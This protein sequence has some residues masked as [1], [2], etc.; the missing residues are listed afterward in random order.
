MRC[1]P[2]TTILLLLAASTLAQTHVTAD[3]TTSRTWTPAGSPFLVEAWV[4]IMPDVSLAI[5][6]GVV[7]KFAPG[8][9]GLAMAER[10]TL[11]AAGTAAAPI[12]F[13][14]AAAVP[15]PGDYVGLG[16][17][18]LGATTI[19][20]HCTI[21]FAQIG[22]VIG[23]PIETTE[24]EVRYCWN[25]IESIGGYGTARASGLRVH[26]N[27][28]G[29]FVEEFSG[30]ELSR[31]RIHDNDY[32]MNGMSGNIAVSLDACEFTANRLG[33]AMLEFGTASGCTFADNGGGGLLL[34]RR[35]VV[36]G[37]TFVSNTGP[38]IIVGPMAPGGS[39]QVNGCNFR[40]NSPFDLAVDIRCQLTSVDAAH[41]WWG[42]TDPAAVAARIWDRTDNPAMSATVIYLPLE[43]QVGSETTTW[44]S[45]KALY[46]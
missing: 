27:N 1:L 46:R 9:T 36:T 42:V 22:L 4:R 43:Q 10:S 37:C 14:S 31:C 23:A 45:A 25:G 24:I 38:G 21:E 11:R 18:H 40:D 33:G 6:P 3:I 28:V 30:A 15:A 32:G 16:V 39:C 7:V 12:L 5:E 20:S 34:G 2:L 41:N 35:A 13:T 17:G 8:Q 26:D 29:V 44:G 19:M